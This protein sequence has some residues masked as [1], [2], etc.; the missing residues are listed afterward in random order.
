MKK[1]LF[2]Y[3][4]AC[5]FIFSACEPEEEQREVMGMKPVYGTPEDL[6]IRFLPAQE[7]CQPGKI[8]LY[9]SYLLIN[10][11]HKG[12]HFI[13]NSD[14]K[15]PVNLGFAKVAG[16]VDMA[17]KNGLLYADHL[18]SLVIL[19][20]SNPAEPAF[21]R[22]VENAISQGKNL[23]PTQSNVVFECVDPDK[24]PVIGWAEALLTDPKCYR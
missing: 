13:D 20:V 15:N 7:I 3:L 10:E 1:S 16:N 4:A 14:P 12:I 5:L 9:G 21:V 22:A 23:Y 11:L 24:G 18:S 8:Y 17:V 6:E 19:D 2:Y